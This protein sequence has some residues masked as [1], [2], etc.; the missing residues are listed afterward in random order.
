MG[1][2]LDSSK[3]DSPKVEVENPTNVNELPI[4]AMTIING[5]QIDL[6]VATTSEQQA[7]G[8]MYRQFLPS[9]RGML[10][11][12]EFPRRATFWMKNV[13]M[14]LDMI[15]LYRG[16]VVS[17]ENNVP[18]CESE[19]CPIYGP[20]AIVDQVLELAGGRA[21]ELNLQRGDRIYIQFLENN[22]R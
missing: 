12:F 14:P 22:V 18:P 10:F 8:L 2:E 19:P 5:E 21:N 7:Q 11:P 13:N 16:K 6:E 1:C 3:A 17:I 9:N 4:T 15:F 20:E